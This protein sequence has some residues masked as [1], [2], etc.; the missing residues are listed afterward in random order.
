MT[1]RAHD[2]TARSPAAHLLGPVEGHPITCRQRGSHTG[3]PRVIPAPLVA[4]RLRGAPSLGLSE[5]MFSSTP[6]RWAGLLLL[7]FACLATARAQPASARTQPTIGRCHLTATVDAGSA[8]YLVDCVQ[9]A[10]AHGWDALLIRIDTPGGSLDSTREIVRSFLASNVPILVW[11]GPAG[12]RAGSAGVF[13]TLAS[14]YAGMAPGT[15]IGAA[16]PVMG[17]TGEDP[18]KAGSHMAEKVVNDTAAFVESIANQ[19]KRNADWAVSAVRDSDSITAEKA[20]EIHVVEVLAAT[21]SAFLAAADG[22]TVELPDGPRVLRTADA[23]MVDLEP[24]LRQ[25]L[26]HWLS[27]PSLAYLL[28]IVGGL[29]LAIELSHPGMI[30]P[31][32]LGVICLILAMM[33]FSALP[34]QAGAIVLSLIGIGLIVAELFVASGLLG[35]AG[36]GLLVLGG[37]LL[38]DR[39]DAEWYVE[40]SWRMALWILLPAAIALGGTAVY[41]MLRAAQAR[42]EPQRGGDLGLIGVKGRALTDVGPEGGT[43]FV[44]GER[45]NAIASHSIPANSPVVVRGLDGLT[46]HVDEVE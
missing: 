37:V 21:E 25:S 42:K 10:E 36:V 18:E 31:G 22:K 38:V 16:H 1:Q 11:V 24:T 26:I 43:V 9:T 45:W 35:V 28:F 8:G 40:P 4:S 3:L 14:H 34:I 41:V 23:Q 44:H 27:N 13:I 33:A 17:P 5:K 30:V 19:R 7:S 46:L 32:V 20:V 6:L 2:G 12:A 15:N 29:G 39:F